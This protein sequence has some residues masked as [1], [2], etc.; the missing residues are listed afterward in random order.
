[1][2]LNGANGS[3]RSVEEETDKRRRGTRCVIMQ[4]GTRR[5]AIWQCQH[6]A[7][8]CDFLPI[9]YLRD[10]LENSKNK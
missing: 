7:C 6:T 5:E 10:I 3:G 2:G 9:Q 4:C 8:K 1:M